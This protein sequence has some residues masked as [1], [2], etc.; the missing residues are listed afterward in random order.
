MTAY[1]TIHRRA[2]F[3][4][5]VHTAAGALIGQAIDME[6][7]AAVKRAKR[8]AYRWSEDRGWGEL[9]IRQRAESE[10]RP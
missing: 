7:D 1:L 9:F 2:R 8:Q 3:V 5:Q 6:Q 4:A 10:A